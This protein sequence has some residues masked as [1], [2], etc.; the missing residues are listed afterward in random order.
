MAQ[1]LNKT[2]MSK[3]VESELATFS[4]ELTTFY[5]HKYEKVKLTTLEMNRPFEA[6][7]PLVMTL[8]GLIIFLHIAN[9]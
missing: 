6:S 8:R 5:R 4:W 2:T 7:T 9:T 1:Q 3:Y